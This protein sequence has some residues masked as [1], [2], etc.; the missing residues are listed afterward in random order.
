MARGKQTEANLPSAPALPDDTE[1]ARVPDETEFSGDFLQ[2][3]RLDLLAVQLIADFG[4]IGWLRDFNVHVLWKREG[5]KSSGSATLGKCVVPSGLT[6]FFARTEDNA[7]PDWLIWI[8]ADHLRDLQFTRY[9]LR[10]LLFHELMHCRAQKKGE[11]EVPASRGHD[12]ELFA[13]EV[14]YFGMWR[15]SLRY[16]GAAFQQLPLPMSD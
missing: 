10:A 4:D 5:G 16:V 7:R 3:A 14:K 15:G 12:A 9:Q 2:D 6:R 11:I 1:D 8:A 13:A